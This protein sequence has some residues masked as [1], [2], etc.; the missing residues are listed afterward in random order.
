MRYTPSD[1]TVRFLTTVLLLLFFEIIGAT[2]LPSLF[3]YEYRFFFLGVFCIYI[4]L[5]I[6]SSLQPYMLLVLCWIHSI[7]SVEGWAINCLI[8]L[9]LMVILSV[10]KDLIQLGTYISRALFY[11]IGLF[12]WDFFRV[13]IISLKSNSFESFAILVT[14]D[15]IANLL[16]AL[17]TPILL[18]PLMG[19]WK[20]YKSIET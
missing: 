20:V 16:L 12:I 10:I 8:A 17:L 1:F 2:V 6:P 11:F 5:E 3:S 7:F 14:D 19:I 4:A 9:I 15:L 18:L 13:V